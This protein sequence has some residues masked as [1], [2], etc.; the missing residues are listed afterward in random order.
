MLALMATQTETPPPIRWTGPPP[1]SGLAGR[2]DRLVGPGATR[3][4][5]LTTLGAGLAG[6]VLAVALAPGEWAA[7]KVALAAV[8][9]FDLVGG[10][11]ANAGAPAQRWYHRPG[12]SAREHLAFAAAH[13]LQLA[14]VALAFRDGDVAYALA[15]Y[16]I[17]LAAVAL[18]LAAPQHLRRAAAL[19]GVLAG[20][21]A[22][23]GIF[24]AAAGLEWFAV[25]FY[26]KLLAAHA[27]REAPFAP[28][29]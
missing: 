3:G 18:V 21:V 26:V 27:N 12:T 10:I 24:G 28:A 17:L 5:N 22:L 7:W 4:E 2:W 14:A 1:R 8:L 6:V 11:A 19:C 15:G 13:G 25:A 9:A 23:D 20:V 16:A 29:R